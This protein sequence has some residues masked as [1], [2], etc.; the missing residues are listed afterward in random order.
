[1]NVIDIILIVYCA[2]LTI[3]VIAY[4]L[5]KDK[6]STKKIM[7]IGRN[8]IPIMFGSKVYY[9]FADSTPDEIIKIMGNPTYVKIDPMGNGTIEYVH[10]ST[11]FSVTHAEHRAFKFSKFNLIEIS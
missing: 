6:E 1:M 7:E 3:V 8:K 10:N 5:S 4:I 9:V 11:I 2:I